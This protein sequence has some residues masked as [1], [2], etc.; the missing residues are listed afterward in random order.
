MKETVYKCRIITPMFMYGEQNVEKER[1]RIIAVPELRT[2]SIKGVMRYVWRAAQA[3]TDC[4]EMSKREGVLFG[5]VQPKACQ[6]GLRLQITEDRRQTGRAPLLPHRSGTQ[7]LKTAFIEN[8]TSF[9][10][11]IRSFGKHQDNH[12]TY[13]AV[14]EM[15]S[16][17]AGFGGRSRRGAG[18]VRLLEKNQEVIPPMASESDVLDTVLLLLNKISPNKYERDGVNVRLTNSS[19]R[20]ADYPYI[21]KIAVSGALSNAG[22]LRKQ[23]NQFSSDYA[24][25]LTG[26]IDVSAGR[27]NYK[28]YASPIIVSVV[29][30]SDGYHAI[31]THLNE[32]SAIWRSSDQSVKNIQTE[33]IK[34]VLEIGRG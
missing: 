9:S 26:G 34:N 30:I 11:I 12:E 3:A 21:K 19:N 14:W 17:L 10:V 1:P 8:N 5:A 33:F 22:E 27:V 31:L 4:E 13:E 20:A 16:L 25:T 28:R 6:S 18:A 24:G 2:A 23:I 7:T 32:A 29:E 15:T